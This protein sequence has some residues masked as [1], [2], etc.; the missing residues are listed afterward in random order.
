LELSGARAKSARE[1]IVSKG[2]ADSRITAKGFGETE[3]KNQCGNDV[4][5]SEEEH[6]INR[7][8]EFKILSME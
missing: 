2:I 6:A 1:Y 8:T 4:K 5:C 7:R 3:L